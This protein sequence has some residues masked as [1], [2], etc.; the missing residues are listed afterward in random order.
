MFTADGLYRAGIIDEPPISE[1]TTRVDY[2]V[3][4]RS[5][6]L[7]ELLFKILQH[8]GRKLF[9]KQCEKILASEAKLP[10]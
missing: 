5:N 2:I 1:H 8:T 4:K 10:D 7:Y 9:A 6:E 3:G